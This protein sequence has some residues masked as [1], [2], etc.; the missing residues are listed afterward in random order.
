MDLILILIWFLLV[1]GFLSSLIAS[2]YYVYVRG[3]KPINIVAKFLA[4]L[5]VFG[6]LT[7]GIGFLAGLTLFLGA[8]SNPPGSVL[9]PKE[10]TIAVL[11]LV[12]YAAC[13]WLMSSFIVGKLI[14]PSIL[15]KDLS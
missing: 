3:S 5:I 15:K 4:G 6:F 9:S 7:L 2:S 1:I 14:L 11:L 10:L 13:C 12:V 8:H